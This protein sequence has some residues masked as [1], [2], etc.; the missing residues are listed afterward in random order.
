MHQQ[1]AIEEPR[2]TEH[3]AQLSTRRIWKK[4]IVRECSK[5]RAEI[6]G[7][8]FNAKIDA[9]RMKKRALAYP[10]GKK[11]P[12]NIFRFVCMKG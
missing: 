2:R 10:Y 4:F 12:V 9:C 11:N 5:L 6:P 8:N 1:Q 7:T 3:A